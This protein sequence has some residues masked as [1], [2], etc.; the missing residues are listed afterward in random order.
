[1]AEFTLHAVC[2]LP[3][4]GQE[5]PLYT[6]IRPPPAWAFAGFWSDFARFGWYLSHFRT[7]G[8]GANI[9]MECNWNHF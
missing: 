6:G 3:A 9:G 1:M 2:P 4:R 5:C 8:R 7:L